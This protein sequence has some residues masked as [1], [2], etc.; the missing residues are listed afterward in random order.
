MHLL[1]LFEAPIEDFNLI[2]NWSKN[3]SFRHE[4]DRKLLTNP[5]A[6]EKIKQQWIK[7]KVPFN[8]LFVNTPEA[9][10]HTEVGEV[11]GQ[12]LQ[13]KMP[14]AFPQ[15]KLRDDAVNVIFTNNKG[16]ERFPMTAWIM[17]HRFGH[18]VARNDWKSYLVAPQPQVQEFTDAMNLVFERVSDLFRDA[19]GYKR[20]IRQKYNGH[21]EYEYKQWRAS[22]SRLVSFFQE[23]GTMRSA[24]NKDLRN[25]FEFFPE[26]LAQYMLSGKI[27]FR[28][29]PKSIRYGRFGH[30]WLAFTGN[31][32]DYDYYNG[33]L[34]DLAEGL[35]DQ[36]NELL[37]A[38]IGRIFVM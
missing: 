27:T 18:V 10:R 26:L 16:D 3:S 13:E 15:M 29:L 24:R 6:Q 2:G 25:A 34:R 5:K 28:P 36:F 32:H 17:A 35:E 21:S 14:K 22:Q 23:I 37:H 7:T 19:Y 31:D 8:L 1:D 33:H 30:S 11:S 12:W 38:V 20:E 9:N 4:Q